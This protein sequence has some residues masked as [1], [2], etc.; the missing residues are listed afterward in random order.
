MSSDR[1]FDGRAQDRKDKR[2]M[3]HYPEYPYS[4]TDRRPKHVLVSQTCW[5]KTTLH[6]NW[7]K[8]QGKGPFVFI[9][10]EGARV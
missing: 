4:M 3:H 1:V 8:M 9:Y 2:I 7:D 10:H 5:C 6:T